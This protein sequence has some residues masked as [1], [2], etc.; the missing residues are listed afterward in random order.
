[1]KVTDS[2]IPDV[3]IVVPARHADPRGFLCETYNRGALAGAGMDFECLQINRLYSIARGTLRGLHFQRPPAAQAKLVSVW[4][5][6]LLDVVVDLRHGSPTFGH[7]VTAVLSAGEGNQIWCPKGFAHG[8]VT[9]EPDTEVAYQL[10]AY[11]A[12]DLELGVRWDDP[13]LKIAWPFPADEC[14]F[15]DRDRRLPR[16]RGLPAYFT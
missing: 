7:H 6:K 5:G 1:M 8:F 9:L 4:R 10:D 11:Y 12:P 16:F 15:S 13:D 14:V 3:K 2:A